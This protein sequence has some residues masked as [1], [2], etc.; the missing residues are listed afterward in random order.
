MKIFFFFDDH[1]KKTNNTQVRS[2]TEAI[3]WVYSQSLETTKANLKK[4]KA[5]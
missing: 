5:I 1:G 3:A 4:K 2:T